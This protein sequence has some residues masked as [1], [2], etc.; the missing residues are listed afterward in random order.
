MSERSEQIVSILENAFADR[1][2]RDPA[3]FRKR[4]RKM[5]ADPFAFY[6]GSAALYYADMADRDDPWATG[7]LS[8]AW[9]HGDLHAENFGTYLNDQ[10]RLIFDVNDF[11][12]AYLGHFTWDLQRCA[13]SL[14]LIGWRKAFPD[15]VIDELIARYIR[16][17]LDQVAYYTQSDRDK[18]WALRLDNAR[19]PVRRTLLD[20]RSASRIDLLTANTV[21]VDE[22]RQFLDGS[23][24]RRLDDDEHER[25]LRAYERYLDTV[26][27]T[28]R[29]PNEIAFEVKDVVGRSGFGI[30]SAGLRAYNVLLEGRSEALENDV[31][32]SVKEGNVAAASAVVHDE[33]LAGAFEHHGH[34]TALSQRALQV[35]TDPYLGWTEIDGTGFVVSELSPY[36]SDLEWDDLTEPDE[37]T[38]L[39]TDLG[40]AT[41]KMH[42]VS[43]ADAEGLAVDEQVENLV[44]ARVDGRV[45]ELVSWVQEFAR[46][47]AELTRA[48]H[49]RFVDAFRHGGFGRVSAVA[50]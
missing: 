9:I 5:A 37:I 19:G 34:R 18:D 24:V 20:A 7:A 40:K 15:E 50:G 6:R 45:G 32:L 31:I 12:E 36:E 38:E 39:V 41:A 42:C 22:D 8:R 29:T 21:V 28:K 30:G 49:A 17:Y 2:R 16:S 1:V 13:A 3:A 23:G 10:G 26:P 35:H 46:E 47:Y 27:Q 4:F 43:D 25:V 48:D 11:D 33:R 44:L 14:A